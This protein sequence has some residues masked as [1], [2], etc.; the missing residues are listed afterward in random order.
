MNSQQS[1]VPIWYYVVSSVLLLW[2]IMGI[3]NYFQ[4][5]FISDEVLQSLPPA[6]QEI[7]LSMPTWIFVVFGIAVFTGLGGS[8]A[9]LVRKRIAKILFIISLIASLIQLTRSINAGDFEVYGT[10]EMVV[11]G[12]I[13]GFSVFAIWL[14]SYANSKTWLR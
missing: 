5:L 3:T 8:V 7:I 9:L 11:T 12:M 13:I 4:H 10:P 2:N 1:K 6:N 14:S